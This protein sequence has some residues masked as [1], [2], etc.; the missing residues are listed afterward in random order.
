MKIYIDKFYA[1]L[2]GSDKYPKIISE[3]HFNRISGYF[4]DKNIIYGGKIDRNTLTI[5][6]TMISAEFNSSCM[7]EEI[8]GPILP[9]IQIEDLVTLKDSL[10]P[11]NESLAL[12]IF[13]KS[14]EHIANITNNFSSG[15]VCINDAL[16]HIS[17]HHLPFGGVGKSG[18]GS[19]HGKTGFNT[20]SNTVS[21]LKTSTTFD[22]CLFYPP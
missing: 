14:K 6:P 5:A 9:I 4:D 21:Y 1:K 15:A 17:N 10:K 2:L 22:S 3:E 8:F 20:F 7:K 11:F 16:M 19:Y 18:I 13:C 12:Y